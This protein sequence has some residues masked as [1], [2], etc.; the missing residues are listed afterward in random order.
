ME[1]KTPS[2]KLNFAI[3]G[4]GHIAAKMARTLDFLRGEV[5]PY[6]VASRSLERAEAIRSESGFERAYGSYAEMLADENVDVVYVATPNH[7]HVAQAKECLAAGKHVVCE[8]PFAL[9][10]AEAESVFSLARERGLFVLEALWTRFQPA[11]RLMREVMASGEIGTPR[12]L[13]ASFALA[14]AHKERVKQPGLGGGALLDLGIY[15]L[16][17]AA[18]HFGLDGIRRISSAATLSPEG[19]DDQSSV[20]IEYADGRMASLTT[21]MTAAY[22]TTSR[23]A[24]TLGCID[25]P[26]L[27]RCESFVVRMVPSGKERVV[28]CP[29]DFNG[30]EYEIRAAAA[31]IRAGRLECPEMPWRETAAIAK[32]MDDLRREWGCASCTQ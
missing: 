18:M 14:I 32:I 16:N 1:K 17:F 3:M 22:G 9:S 30:Y 28:S 12:F 15:P 24:G 25:A 29:F 19:V 5:H 26:Q 11:A 4:A 21:S 27:T 6:A 7:V 8:K 20:T 2:G 10:A 31:A 23:I 13:Q